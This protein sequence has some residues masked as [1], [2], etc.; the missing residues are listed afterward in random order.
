MAEFPYSPRTHSQPFLHKNNGIYYLS[1]GC[2]YATGSSP[3]GPFTYTGSR[4]GPSGG[5][6]LDTSA[7][8]P[9][10]RMN[11]TSGP[12]YSWE[13]Y[14]GRHGCVVWGNVGRRVRR[15]TVAAPSLQVILGGERA[16]VLC[17][18]RSVLK[19]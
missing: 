15:C 10:F 16:V 14:L 5:S 17:N 6:V 9:D 7:I 3:Y 19:W 18:N 12:W 8:A 2:F 11:Q 4:D 1:W 13:D